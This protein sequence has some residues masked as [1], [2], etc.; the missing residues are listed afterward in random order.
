MT[1]IFFGGYASEPSVVFP[2]FSMLPGML[3]DLFTNLQ[4]LS[5]FS[6]SRATQG[7]RAVIR[8]VL[9]ASSSYFFLLTNVQT[10]TI[11]FGVGARIAYA[12]FTPASRRGRVLTNMQFPECA[13]HCFSHC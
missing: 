10:W 9:S 1:G 5:D 2:L 3:F 12:C 7:L 11:S 6:A 4:T 13:F 8:T